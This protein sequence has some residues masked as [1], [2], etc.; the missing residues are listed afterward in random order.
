MAFNPPRNRGNSRSRT[1]GAAEAV[2]RDADQAAFEPPK[3]VDVPD[4]SGTAA[5]Q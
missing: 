5:Q 3:V 2:P 4:G 1:S